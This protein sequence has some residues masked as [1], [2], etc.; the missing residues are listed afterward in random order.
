MHIPICMYI[1]FTFYIHMYLNFIVRAHCFS[2]HC[3]TIVK[4]FFLCCGHNQTR[5][6][7]IYLFYFLLFLLLPHSGSHIV[8]H[9]RKDIFIIYSYE[10]INKK[11]NVNFFFSSHTFCSVSYL[12]PGV[13]GDDKIPCGKS[14]GNIKDSKLFTS[15]L[16]Y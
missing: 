4:L 16:F 7:L 6:V 13:W 10:V 8:L 2:M 12:Y 11:E 14:A 15:I 5:I 9:T 1:T 3:A